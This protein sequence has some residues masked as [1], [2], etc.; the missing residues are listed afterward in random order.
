MSAN[1]VIIVS[2]ARTA[3]G[4][5]NGLLKDVSAIQLGAAAIQAVIQRGGI[6]HSQVQEVLMGNALQAGLGQNPAR[7]AS[8]Q[9]GVPVAV[10]AT[11]VNQVCGS[12]LMALQIAYRSI[13]SGE[14]DVIVA[15]GMENMSQAPH[16]L[17]GTRSGY[18][19]GD[20]KLQDSLIKDGLWCAQNNYHMGITAEHLCEKYNLT[21]EQLDQYALNSQRKAAAAVALGNF[22]DE[23]VALDVPGRKGTVIR[24]DRDEYPRPDTTL[25]G[26][27]K[28]KAAFT[29]EGKVT[30]GNASGI[31]DG[32][33][34]LLMMSR[35]RAA[36]SDIR[37]LAVVRSC[38]VVGV[39]PAYMGIGPIPATE[40]ALMKA[41]LSMSDIDLIEV[42]EAFAS[43]ALLFAQHFDLDDRK[44]NVNGGAIALGHPIGASGARVMVSLLY[45]MARRHSQYGLATLCV[46]GGQG[47]AV[48]VERCE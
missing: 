46:G 17:Q 6:P 8:L 32:A 12:G 29:P 37:P 16:L 48:I 36:L 43:Q 44:L 34:A 19:M 47:V 25:E 18:V 31:N 41:G 22:D 23:I 7:Q 30:A 3:I 15:G 13:Q 14:C 45:E 40:K 9:A 1:E 2:A 42:N 35:T 26:L 38:A 39:D 33:A 10:P 21:R 11:T 20:Q 28:L 4:K 24:A 27:S 5:F